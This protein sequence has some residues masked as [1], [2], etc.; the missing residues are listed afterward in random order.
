MAELFDPSRLSMLGLRNM[1]VLIVDDIAALLVGMSPLLRASGDIDAV[2]TA[3]N[4]LEAVTS[5]RELI[6]NACRCAK[7]YGDEIPLCS[8]FIKGDLA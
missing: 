8:P 2:G 7:L 1:W 3:K 5:S 4:G 6:N